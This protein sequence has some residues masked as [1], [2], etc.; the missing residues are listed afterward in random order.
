[1]L[2]NYEGN[3]RLRELALHHNHRREFIL[4]NQKHYDT[5]KEVENLIESNKPIP[6]DLYNFFP[7]TVI[8]LCQK[9]KSLHLIK[10]CQSRPEYLIKIKCIWDYKTLEYLANYD[11]SLRPFIL[12]RFYY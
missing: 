11:N 7:E 12:H 9:K 3:E 6:Q 4:I 5:K 2:E 10:D 1:M 8:D